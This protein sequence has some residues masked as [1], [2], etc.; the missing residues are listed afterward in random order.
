MAGGRSTYRVV[1]AVSSPISV[2]MGPDSEFNLIVTSVSAVSRPTSVG[3]DPFRSLLNTRRAVTDVIW[4]SSVG[5]VP[6]SW[7]EFV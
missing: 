2:G 1:S 3:M 6:V 5:I 7:F 4:P